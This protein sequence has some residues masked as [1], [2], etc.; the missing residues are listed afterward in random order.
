TPAMEAPEPSLQATVEPGGTAEGWV[1]SIVNDTSNVIY[2]FS[3]PFLG[4]SW[5]NAW[6]A[7]SDG[8]QFP[9][10]DP[11]P[12]DSGLGTS[13]ESPATFGETVRAGDFDV[14][15]QEHI[16]GQAVYDIAD[17]GLRALA[18]SSGF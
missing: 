17:F 18:V 6:L 11:V 4:G 2:S 15:V 13:P 3:S 1:P 14:S 5:S 12:E 7:V 10:V 9:A 16:Q 8:A